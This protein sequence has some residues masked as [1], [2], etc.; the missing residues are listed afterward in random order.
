[1]DAV[2]H[3]Y[4]KALVIGGSNGIGLS[5]VLNLA[6]R[7][8]NVV[9]MDKVAPDCELPDNVSY[10]HYNLLNDCFEDNA[11]T[12]GVGQDDIDILVV[13]AG[14][15]ESLEF[16]SSLI[17]NAIIMG[18]VFVILCIIAGFFAAKTITNPLAAMGDIIEETAKLDFGSRNRIAKLEVRKDE[19]GNV[20]KSIA[21]MNLFG[22]SPVIFDIAEKGFSCLCIFLYIPY[23]FG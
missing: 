12:A 10:Y 7:C 23:K 1:M 17:L 22:L 21:S 19:I 4:K 5:I 2:E 14:E 8:R 18:A 13:T 15:K 9:I 11:D 6:A 16:I 20:S 3:K